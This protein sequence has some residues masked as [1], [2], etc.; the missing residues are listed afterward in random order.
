M[1]C[2]RLYILS[3]IVILPCT[4]ASGRGGGATVGTSKSA[5]ELASEHA[6]KHA[7]T[8]SQNMESA[9]ELFTKYLEAAIEKDSDGKITRMVPTED[10]ERLQLFKQ[11]QAKTK[12]AQ[13]AKSKHDVLSGK[14]K[15]I[16]PLQMWKPPQQQ[17][18]R[19]SK[20]RGGKGARDKGTKKQQGTAS[21]RKRSS[22][23]S[24]RSQP[25]GREELDTTAG[26]VEATR[27]RQSL[28]R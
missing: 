5:H 19:A 17:G 18:Q 22:R 11:S 3:I 4:I 12:L 24:S 2:S 1:L 25:D 21:S 14:H 26:P 6:S 20:Q 16:V 8:Y 13:E 27:N 28:R 10:K 15:N 23:R 9:H 7:S